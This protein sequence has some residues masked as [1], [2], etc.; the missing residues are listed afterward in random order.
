MIDFHGYGPRLLAGA[1][2]TTELALLSLL[3]AVVLG[4]LAASARLS[5]LRS[6]AA[7]S[8][9]YTTL[10]R[11]VPDL[12]LLM[13][14]FYGGQIG[15]NMITDRLYDA[16]DIDIFINIDAFIAG[17]ATLGV[18]YGA[19]MA[20]TF[21]GAFMAVDE[22]QM[23]AARAYGMSPWLVFSRIRFPLMM[24]HALPGLGN[25]WLVMLKSTALVSII[26]LT[27]M[28][29]VAEKATKA[30]HEP[31]LFMLPVAVGYL[32]MTAVSELAMLW[33]RRRYDTG[34]K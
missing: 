4:L 27:D 5:R 28:V 23:E 11:G 18:I 9:T 26:G 17:V 33:L 25:N 6:V 14:L 32:L 12:V 3:V 7:I 21:R 13:L 19:Y 31:F 20:E 30:T 24:R 16:F 2:L 15:V 22:G 8:A 29:R 34:F 1:W 10:I